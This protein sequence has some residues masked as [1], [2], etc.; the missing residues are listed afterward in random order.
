MQNPLRCDT[1]ALVDSRFEDGRRFLEA[2]PA[3]VQ[4]FELKGDI[5]QVWFGDLAQ[6]ARKPGAKRLCGFT[7]DSDRFMASRLCAPMRMQSRRL[8]EHDSR[9]QDVLTHTLAFEPAAAVRELLDTELWP[10]ALANLDHA[11][12]PA[13]GQP[14][15]VRTQVRR[16][17]D[18]PGYLVSWV[19]DA[20]A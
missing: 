2:L 16:S 7:T 14:I 20:P 19:V 15:V 5:S 11:T 12:V 13:A 8:A 6:W 3:G 4:L 17:T 1:A 9:R 18:F 10:A